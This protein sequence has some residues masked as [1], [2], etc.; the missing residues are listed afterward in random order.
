MT[1]LYISNL[2]TVLI[3]LGYG[4]FINSLIFNENRAVKIQ[5]FDIFYGVIYLSFIAILINFF[6][7]LNKFINSLLILFGI[8]ISIRVFINLKNFT[9]AIKIC[10]YVASISFIIMLLAHS[11]RPDAGLY[12]LPFISILN[13]NKIIFGI[14]NIHFRFAHTSIL[15]YISAVFN[16]YLFLDKGV[17]LPISIILSSLLF[18]FYK[19]FKLN[20][21]NNFFLIFNFLISSFTI[22]KVSRY[23]DIGNDSIGHLFFFLIIWYFLWCIS[24]SKND[25]K[26]F[27]VLSLFSIF[28]FAN[29]IF[30]I[31]AFVFPIFFL[32]W[33]NKYKYLIDKKTVIL[34][35]L[36]L[37]IFIKNIIISSCIIYPI[38]TSCI[39][40]FSWSSVD[41]K[42]HS[43]PVIRS[44]EGEAAA[45]G[46]ATYKGKGG[47]ISYSKY[48]KNFTWLENWKETH[49]IYTLKKILPLFLLIIFILSVFIFREKFK[50]FKLTNKDELFFKSIIL[51]LLVGI[52]GTI[53]WFL[54]F[55]IYRYGYSLF[56][57]MIILVMSFTMNFY[58]SD[59]NKIGIK[60]IF[61]KC[62][63]FFIIFVAI[64]NL[65]RISNNIKT[66]YKDYPWP[67]IYAF[68]ERNLLQK[69]TVLYSFKDFNI[70]KPN[71][72]LCMY[73]NSP[74]THFSNIKT[75]I[76][77][78]KK[79]NYIVIFPRKN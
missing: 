35:F 44:I 70:Y 1:F 41:K 43:D 54:S 40:S 56:V 72:R 46:W 8:I 69:N 77:I 20:S 26:S 27:Y 17:S 78:K 58:F 57:S 48:N 37:C 14:S 21:K 71:Y 22:L 25:Y 49:L 4:N 51:S 76:D 75:Q 38:K 7:P 18:N 3:F 29:K 30:L 12:H 64:Q 16:N 68:D 28:A 6:F 36:L 67:K 53:Y 60:K 50:S 62:L 19:N 15:Q 59:K 23:N 42:T 31:F 52:F 73:S 34:L 2:L 66:D 45:K 55:P 33:T 13:E 10:F 65:I 11:N 47:E 39:S 61:E 5:I 74:C 63:I 32:I 79:G 24:K 9:E